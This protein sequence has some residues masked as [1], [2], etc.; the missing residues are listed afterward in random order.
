MSARLPSLGRLLHRLPA[1]GPALL[2]HSTYYLPRMNESLTHPPLKREG[3]EGRRRALLTAASLALQGPARHP[4]F[5][6]CQCTR[7]PGCVHAHVLRVREPMWAT[8]R[9]FHGGRCLPPGSQGRGRCRS[10]AAGAR[11]GGSRHSTHTGGLGPPD[12]GTGSSRGCPWRSCRP[13]LEE[14]QRQL[15]S[16]PITAVPSTLTHS[17]GVPPKAGPAWF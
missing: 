8:R 15:G 16:A 2:L 11:G 13:P 17:L 7:V 4:M 14:T 3:P 10:W 5:G 1:P 6:W 12:P 9:G